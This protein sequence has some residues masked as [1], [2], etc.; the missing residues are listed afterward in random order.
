MLLASGFPRLFV[1]VAAVC[2]ARPGQYEFVCL[3]LFLEM[4][5]GRMC[6]LY[7]VPVVMRAD[8]IMDGVQ[9]G[10]ADFTKAA[11]PAT[12]GQAI[13]VPDLMA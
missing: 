6:S 7:C 13:D 11:A 3:V 4:R 5:M 8:L 2:P 1:V 12:C 10:C 9:P